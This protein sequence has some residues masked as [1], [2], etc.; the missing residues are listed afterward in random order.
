MHKIT[1]KSENSGAVFGMRKLAIVKASVFWWV[2]VLWAL[3]FTIPAFSLQDK[4]GTSTIL[5]VKTP[6]PTPFSSPPKPIDPFKKKYKKGFKFSPSCFRDITIRVC[7]YNL[8]FHAYEI[9]TGEVLIPLSTKN[10]D[11]LLDKFGTQA[12]YNPDTQIVTFT[13]KDGKKLRFKINYAVSDHAGQLK[14]IPIPPRIIKGM[15]YISPNSFSK[16]IWASFL[17]DKR[18]DLYYLDPYI[19]SVKLERTKRGLTKVV[20]QGTAPLHP[21]ILKLRN[22]TRFVID[23][24]N[25]VL[26][27]KAGKIH[28]PTLGFIRYSQH[29]LM[30]KDGNIVRIV[31]PQSEEIEIALG[32]PRS[33][34][35][36]EAELRVRQTSAPVQDLPLEKITYF[37]VIEKKDLVVIVMKATGPLQMEWNRLLPPDDRFFIDIPRAIYP[38][39]KKSF[40]LK[41]SFLPKVRIAQFQPKPNAKVRIVLPLEGPRRVTIQVD[42]KNP[43]KVK[44]YIS[45]EKINID[46]VA[47]KG[48]LIT[49]YPT[50][51]LVICIDP[52]HGGSDPGAL[53]NRLKLKEKN[54]T[55]DIARRLKRQLRREGWTVIMT[56][57]GDRD[58]TYPGSP[59][60]EELNARAS[61][62]NDLKASIFVSIHINASRN[63]LTSGFATYWY[64]RKDKALAYYI[65]QAM[66]SK[67]KCR[68]LGIRRAK[69][70]VL[71]KTRMPAILV[72]AGFIS[73]LWEA[74]S[75]SK[76][77]FRQKIAD[78]IMDGLRNYAYYT[79]L[80]KSKR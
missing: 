42:K 75:L 29:E 14:E 65:Q 39:R 44:F 11:I 4:E 48:F 3:L 57:N 52:G 5:P 40:N 67:I 24:K 43:K 9:D 33:P 6:I 59:D 78:A 51:G 8:K 73:N 46:K 32:K 38:P 7:G 66:V 34:F 22:P 69:F 13:R 19:I 71:R 64:K 60:Y 1:E 35:F 23:I 21:K 26:D 63:P 79:G 37:N 30:G 49:Y 50:K 58:V 36:V 76:P 56:R 28:H 15:V 80:K 31:V 77:S 27:G 70:L 61:I 53:N 55:L 62:A 17:Y 2:V 18:K 25:S 68:N 72:E 20:A 41:C 16:F 10:T 47:R 45:K 54:I 74:K 12:S